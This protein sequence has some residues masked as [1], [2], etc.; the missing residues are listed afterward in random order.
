MIKAPTTA[1]RA[2]NPK[3]S[4][5]P[6]SGVGAALFGGRFNRVG[7][8]ALYF[9]LRYE[10]AVLEATQ[11]F[12]AKMQPLTIVRY[13]VDCSDIVDLTDAKERKR[14]QVELSDL[15]CS[16][17]LLATEG[18]AVPT[19]DLVDRFKAEGAAGIIVR[20]FSTGA[21]R[22]DKNLVLWKWGTDL[23]H[24]VVAVD[25]EGRLP[26]GSRST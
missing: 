15:A 1:F 12:P 17:K 23:P 19:W 6:T 9:G 3:W 10:T 22:T 18:K 26:T 21:K 25:D 8:E 2:H 24:R 14:L 20:S 4:F 13:D 5:S 16:W 7:D 11:G